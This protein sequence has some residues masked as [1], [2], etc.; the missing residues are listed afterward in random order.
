MKT[1]LLQFLTPGNERVGFI[2]TDGEVVEVQN[3]CPEPD[4]GFEV[5]G[6]DLVLYEDRIAATWHTHPGQDSNLSVNDHQG[7]IENPGFVHFIVG[8]DG[9]SEYY[10][11]KGIVKRRD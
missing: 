6:E 8:E 11:E 9:V 10:V 5:R 1:Q 2:L 3:I 7:F 4:Q